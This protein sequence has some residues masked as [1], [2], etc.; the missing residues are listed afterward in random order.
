MPDISR[1]RFIRNASMGVAAAGVVAVAGTGAVGVLSSADAAP[2]AASPQTP[3]LAGS[4]VFAHVEDA[5]TGRMTIFVG[6]KSIH[7]TNHDLA[8][9]LLRAA[10]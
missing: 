4:A 9:A 5:T 2:R 10:Q 3:N 1:R 7:V 6:T 8:Q